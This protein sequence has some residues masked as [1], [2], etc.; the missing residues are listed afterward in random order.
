MEMNIFLIGFRCSGKT[1]VGRELAPRMEKTF[2]DS[3]H[4]FVE[5]FGKPIAEIVKNQGWQYFRKLEKQIIKEICRE[6]GQV[7]ATGGGV[8]LNAANVAVMKKNGILVWLRAD[9]ETTRKRMAD[10]LN[11][12]D[13]RPSLTSKGLL[14]EIL[15]TIRNRQQ[16]YDNASNF[17]IDTDFKSIN[18]I[19]NFIIE[20]I[21]L[22]DKSREFLN[23]YIK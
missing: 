15:L 14:E 3:D 2:V 21:A 4:K 5:T 23:A 1:S 10:D 20:K 7:V 8:V 12:K 22:E 17:S 9:A 19:C 13:Q 6:R 11:T 16:Y 18:E